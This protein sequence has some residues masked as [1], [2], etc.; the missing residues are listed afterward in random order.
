MWSLERLQEYVRQRMPS[1]MPSRESVVTTSTTISSERFAEV[2]A[3]TARRILPE[4]GGAFKK[5]F[6]RHKKAILRD[7]AAR[8]REFQRAFRASWRG[9]LEKLE[10]IVHAAEE[11]HDLFRDRRS[12]ESPD[13]RLLLDVLAGLHLRGTRVSEEVLHLLKAGYASAANARWRT[14][15][16]ITVVALFIGRHPGAAPLYVEHEAVESYKIAEEL[17]AHHDAIADGDVTS[18]EL[19]ALRSRVDGLRERHGKDFAT[20][21]GWAGPFLGNR[22]PKFLHLEESLALDFFKPYYRMASHPIHAT[23][24]GLAFSLEGLRDDAVDYGGRTG[25][26]IADP[27]QSMAMSLLKLTTELLTH[28]PTLAN[29]AVLAAFCTYVDEVQRELVETQLNLEDAI[30]QYADGEPLNDGGP[31]QPSEADGGS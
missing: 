6:S 24:K 31:E 14:L 2:S 19:A 7:R 5:K 15:H 22:S 11:A 4:L 30:A 18:E 16:E 25:M 9:P 10:V 13:R 8:E 1:D 3:D 23:A 20:P 12:N 21:F 27:G 17:C 29:Y 28:Q 26:G